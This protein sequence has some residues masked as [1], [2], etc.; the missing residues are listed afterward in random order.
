MMQSL[1]LP[2]AARQRALRSGFVLLGASLRSPL[3]F[4]RLPTTDR[5]PTS[6]LRLA[7]Q[8]VPR[9][10]GLDKLLSDKFKVGADATAAAGPV[11]KSAA[12]GT[13]IG[14]HLKSSPTRAA[15]ELLPGSA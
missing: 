10:Q 6:L 9:T 14:L 5:S 1:W 13:D 3:H 7:A 8:S 15:G 2:S 11:G 12:A 4:P